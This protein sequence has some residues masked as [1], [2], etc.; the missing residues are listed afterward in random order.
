MIPAMIH[1]TN[2]YLAGASTEEVSADFKA[3]TASG[4]FVAPKHMGVNYMMSH[5]NYI[6]LQG[7]GR[8]VRVRPH[9]MHYA[10][11]VTDA[12]I[13]AVKDA[14]QKGM[15]HIN[16][17][18][19]HGYYISFVESPSDITDVQHACAGQVGDFPPS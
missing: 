3:R 11:N 18:G 17:Q 14:Q 19:I 6:Y 2:M 9:L 5:Y 16:D 7:P 13:A 1:K 12:D 15:P 8:V 10:S 4:E